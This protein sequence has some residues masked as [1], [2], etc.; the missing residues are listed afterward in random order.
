MERKRPNISKMF[1]KLNF[2]LFIR[3]EREMEPQERE[4]EMKKEGREGRKS[5][6][7]NENSS[8]LFRKQFSGL[9]EKENPF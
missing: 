4:K 5:F 6:G 8:N 2:D 9:R 7:R 1:S 3:L